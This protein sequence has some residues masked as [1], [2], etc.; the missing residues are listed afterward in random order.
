[1][2]LDEQDAARWDGD[3][4]AEAEALLLRAGAMGVI[5]RYQLE[6]AIQSAH[7]ARR[8]TGR[9]DWP[10]IER[11]YDALSAMTDSPV[12][13]MNR[14]VT[15]AETRGAEAGLACLDAV[16]ADRRL[17]DYQPYWAA[18]AE[19]LARIGKAEAADQAYQRA[20]GLASDP[21][22]RE[23]LQQRQASLRNWRITSDP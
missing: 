19:L 12:V 4:L 2:P 15:I 17:A 18:R 22:V 7:V 3:M 11:L 23:Y 1:V 21:A 13:A 9:T 20:I 6:A 16:G 8:T 14:A 10:A 5:G